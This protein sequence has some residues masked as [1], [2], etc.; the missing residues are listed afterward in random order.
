MQTNA[1]RGS[2]AILERSGMQLDN[3]SG[4]YSSPNQSLFAKL[5]PHSDT[6]PK[7][8]FVLDRNRATQPS[9]IRAALPTWSCDYTDFH[10]KSSSWNPTLPSPR[11]P[12]TEIPPPPPVFID[13]TFPLPH[14]LLFSRREREP[15]TIIPLHLLKGS[16]TSGKWWWV[17][18]R[19]VASLL[20]LPAGRRRLW[21]MVVGHRRRQGSLH[22]RRNSASLSTQRNNFL[23]HKAPLV[24]TAAHNGFLMS[25]ERESQQSLPLYSTVSS[26]M[27][28]T[29]GSK[30]DKANVH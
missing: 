24:A 28:S 7:Q 25:H 4:T 21:G 18:G 13:R 15:V 8:P 22:V 6:E 19:L 1:G 17:E 16:S 26:W 12:C 5:T 10:E 27:T 23:K 14:K 9:P 29:P 20:L 2:L 3:F 11:Y 30:S